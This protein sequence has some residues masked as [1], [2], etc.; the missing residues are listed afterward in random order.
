MGVG[1]GVAE[2]GAVDVVVVVEGCWVLDGGEVV[3]SRC[4]E[5]EVLVVGEDMTGGVSGRSNHRRQSFSP[6]AGGSSWPS[7]LILT[8]LLSF[9]GLDTS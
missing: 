8:G 7:L 9:Q 4:V 3:V 2:V 1:K 5:F 6:M